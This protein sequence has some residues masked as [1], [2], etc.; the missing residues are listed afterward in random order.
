MPGCFQPKPRAVVTS[1]RD[2]LGGGQSGGPCVPIAGQRLQQGRSLV[3]APSDYRS[4]G[5]PQ[6]S[7]EAVGAVLA[8]LE[9]TPGFAA[10][11][12]P[13]MAPTAAP[14]VPMASPRAP[15]AEGINVTQIIHEQNNYDAGERSLATAVE[16]L[17]RSR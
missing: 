11:Y 8:A 13:S 6:I 15:G 4:L 12:R 7:A 3:P 5:A 1:E 16:H 14:P 17:G 10:T 2:G 9:H